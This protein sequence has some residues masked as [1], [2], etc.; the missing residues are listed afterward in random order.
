MLQPSAIIFPYE[1]CCVISG[2]IRLPLLHDVGILVPL[3]AIRMYSMYI[4]VAVDLVAVCGQPP[5]KCNCLKQCDLSVD[6][7]R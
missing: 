2:Y 3:L 7:K 1:Y 5:S 4:L 6:L